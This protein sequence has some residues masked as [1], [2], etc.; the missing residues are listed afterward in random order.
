[1]TRLDEIEGDSV[2]RVRARIMLRLALDS[3]FLLAKS[4][5]KAGHISAV[6]EAVVLEVP[7][8]KKAE[9]G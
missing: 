9:G 1:L 8:C 5:Y 7:C 6:Y 2:I 4:N 3:E